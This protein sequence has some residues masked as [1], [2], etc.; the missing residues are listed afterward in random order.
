[1]ISIIDIVIAI[2]IVIIPRI[3]TGL[4]VEALHKSHSLSS[5]HSSLVVASA[6]QN[7]GP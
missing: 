2:T 1:M 3:I 6:A 5:H 7:G 4:R